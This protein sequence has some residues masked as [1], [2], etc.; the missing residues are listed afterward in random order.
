MIRR[1]QQSGPSRRGH[2]L[3]EMVLSLTLLSIV[4]VSVGSAV[5]FAAQATPS[6]DSPTTTLIRDAGLLG[7]ISEDIAQAK[8]VLERTPNAITIVVP[9]RTGD[10]I[11]DRI[12]YAWSGAAGDPLTY[13]INGG[14]AQ[15]LEDAVQDFSLA[16]GYTTRTVTI[17]AGTTTESSEILLSEHNVT[18]D[19][20]WTIKKSTAVGHR[21]TP[22]LSA[23]A[24]GYRVTRAQM[25][26]ES[27]G[28]QSGEAPVSVK[29]ISGNT[30][31]STVYATQTLYESDLSPSGGWFEVVFPSSTVVPAGQEA[32]LEFGLGPS[33]GN[34]AEVQTAS[35]GTSPY[36]YT[37][38]N[39]NTWGVVSG[40][41]LPHRVYGV[42]VLAS[43]GF[44]VTSE[45]IT[46]INIALQ[47]SNTIASPIQKSVL[48]LQA[49]EVLTAFW[50]TD[51]DSDPTTTDL[52]NDGTLDMGFVLSTNVPDGQ[53]VDGVWNATGIMY[54]QP[55]DR[56]TGVV[57]IDARM[58]ASS[59]MK[60]TIAGPFHVDSAGQLMPLVT[61]LEDDG[62]GGQQL[63]LYNQ[64]IPITPMATIPDLPAGWVDVQLIV[65]P[66]EDLVFVRVNS[67][68]YGSAVLSRRADNGISR[69][70]QFSG[71]GTG[72]KF[73]EYRVSVG[74]TYAVNP[75]PGSAGSLIISGTGDASSTASS[76]TSS[77][78]DGL[79]SAIFGSGG[80]DAAEEEE[81]TGKGKGKKKK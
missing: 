68:D 4:M 9:D 81:D 33:G 47:S 34:H 6:D 77:V 31:G 41:Y 60:P 75:D 16:Y 8:Y 26:A 13:A 56:F 63:K 49:P 67:V 42:E 24:T 11:P 27:T 22:T 2:T 78:L 32:V 12:R 10:G 39:G 40:N 14:T 17:A 73:N 66:E 54:V 64:V 57:R 23:A 21:F 74:G 38:N 53:I 37:Q 18:P 43:S 36:V 61:R 28:A 15:N 25:M 65:I 29:D 76:S 70:V 45:H 30:P 46:D 48:M 55:T 71:L 35:Q 19:S 51:F 3:L 80:A 5:M 69:G 50:E 20:T 72:A 79:F 1:D 52:D 58:C 7:R 62:S 59:S 44:D